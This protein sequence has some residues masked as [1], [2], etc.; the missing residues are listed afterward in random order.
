MTDENIDTRP[1]TRSDLLDMAFGN[2]DPLEPAR[3]IATFADRSN[4]MQVHDNGRCY[5]AMTGPTCPPYE[6]AEAAMRRLGL[7]V[8]ND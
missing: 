4:W 8:D 2:G 6:L 5:W 3:V 7:E 1:V